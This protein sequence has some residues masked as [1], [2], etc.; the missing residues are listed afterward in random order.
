MTRFPLEGARGGERRALSGLMAE[1]VLS[2]GERRS[3][4]EGPE[5]LWS[6]FKIKMAGEIA[7]AKGET[8][9]DGIFQAWL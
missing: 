1:G 2:N 8:L 3:R 7:G 6:G 9:D 4:S 5:L